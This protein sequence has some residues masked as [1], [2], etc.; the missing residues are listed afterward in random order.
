MKGT[1]NVVGVLGLGMAAER[2]SVEFF[3]LQPKPSRAKL[4]GKLSLITLD[5]FVK[6]LLDVKKRRRLLSPISVLGNYGSTADGV[7]SE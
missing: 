2:V 4:M 1:R 7:S 3:R 5:D 6:P